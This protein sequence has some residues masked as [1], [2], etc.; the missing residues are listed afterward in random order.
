MVETNQDELETQRIK[1]LNIIIPDQSNLN[2]KLIQNSC[3]EENND[4][5]NNINKSINQ[6][7]NIGIIQEIDKNHI[8]DFNRRLDEDKKINSK[9]RSKGILTV[10]ANLNN[11]GNDI[12]KN[13][14]ANSTKDFRDHNKDFLNKEEQLVKPYNNNSQFLIEYQVKNIENYIINEFIKSSNDCESKTSSKIFSRLNSKNCMNSK[15]YI[16]NNINLRLK[17]KNEVVEIKNDKITNSF[18]KRKSFNNL[19]L[20][21]FSEMSTKHAINKSREQYEK[22]V[23]SNLVCSSI[24]LKSKNNSRSQK[25]L[26]VRIKSQKNI[27]FKQ[28]Y[29]KYQNL[30]RQYDFK[31]NLQNFYEICKEFKIT[32]D[33]KIFYEIW[34]FFNKEERMLSTKELWKIV[35][36]IL[37]CKIIF[38]LNAILFHPRSEFTLNTH[39]KII[40][41]ISLLDFPQFLNLFRYAKIDLKRSKR[42]TNSVI[43]IENKNKNKNYKKKIEGFNDLSLNKN[44]FQK[45]L[46]TSSNDISE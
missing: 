29:E 38:K 24:N 10:E 9:I 18:L 25:S 35:K 1:S 44:S 40:R 6:K 5:K 21:I 27:L 45:S 14:K 12:F 28:L 3:A 23:N 33:W 42:H 36:V 17:E 39:D 26:F 22:R 32:G 19:T 41:L 11:I 31:G 20:Q 8:N 4:W 34:N 46:K 15:N 7:E 2:T 43:S 30:I 16:D 37:K 13:L